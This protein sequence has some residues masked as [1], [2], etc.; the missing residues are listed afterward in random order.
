MNNKLPKD[1][2]HPGN[3]TF[4]ECSHKFGTLRFGEGD[5]IAYTNPSGNPDYIVFKPREK[6]TKM[7]ATCTKD[8][9]CTIK[10]LLFNVITSAE[11]NQARKLHSRLEVW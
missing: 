1:F 2:E 3:K 10:E 5:V 7:C 11:Q 8:I 6:I 9:W 4:D